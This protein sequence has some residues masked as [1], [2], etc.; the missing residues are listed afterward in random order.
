MYPVLI[1]LALISF[2]LA[3]WSLNSQLKTKEIKKVK[4]NL[5]KGRVIYHRRLNQA[6]KKY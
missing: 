1:V 4:E 3:L 5:K 6:S 2:I